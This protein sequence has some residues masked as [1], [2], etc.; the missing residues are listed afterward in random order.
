VAVGRGPRATPRNHVVCSKPLLRRAN[1]VYGAR[2]RQKRLEPNLICR[3]PSLWRLLRHPPPPWLLDQTPQL[4]PPPHHRLRFD[5]ISRI[6]HAANFRFLQR[7]YPL[8]PALLRPT[9][10]RS[11]FGTWNST[12]NTVPEH[13]PAGGG[14]PL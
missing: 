10:A 1:G 11:S 6:N 13:R 8:H 14:L 4:Q 2:I 9:C 12:R 3:C 5:R 7:R